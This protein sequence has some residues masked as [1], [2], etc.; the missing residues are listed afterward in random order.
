MRHLTCSRRQYLACI[1]PNCDS[2]LTGK[3]SFYRPNSSRSISAPQIV[4]PPPA[5]DRFRNFGTTNL[6]VE[7]RDDEGQNSDLGCLC[8]C[9][10]PAVR[11]TVSKEGA[12]KGRPFFTCPD[13]RACSFFEWADEGAAS[14]GTK[15]SSKCRSAKS[16]KTKSSSK[17]SAPA[18][19]KT[20]NQ[21]QP[22]TPNMP[23]CSCQR[24]SVQFTVRK[25]GPNQ[26]RQFFTCS[27]KTCNF[28]EWSD[29]PA[30]SA[31]S[32]APTTS[33]A[34]HQSKPATG[35]TRKPPTCSNC[36]VPGHTKRTCPQLKI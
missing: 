27:D 16:T 26:G 28:F 23:N 15:S 9:Q 25:E 30:Q 5:S 29:A 22:E 24:P 34:S 7:N 18:R 19:K 31:T 35:S 4:R 1:H 33:S 2:D 21:G 11:L 3:F 32:K 14:G 6:Q 36:H 12:N 20:K 8:Q 13:N 17:S 10:K